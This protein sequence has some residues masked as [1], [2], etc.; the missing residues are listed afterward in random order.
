M[1]VYAISKIEVTSGSPVIVAS[2]FGSKM[3][4]EMYV[5]LVNRYEKKIIHARI[6][7]MPNRGDLIWLDLECFKVE[8]VVHQILHQDGSLPSIHIQPATADEEMLKYPNGEL[9]CEYEV[10]HLDDK[11]ES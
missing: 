9:H 2:D 10:Q 4:S 7:S 11:H 3:M 6:Q 5:Q 1:W 8:R